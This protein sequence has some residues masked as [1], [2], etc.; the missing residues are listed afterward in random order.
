[1]NIPKCAVTLKS[2]MGYAPSSCVFEGRLKGT[3]QVATFCQRQN[4]SNTL[5][6]PFFSLV[7]KNQLLSEMADQ[8]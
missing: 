1:M 3:D 4:S 5:S 7:R 6:F 2:V 8:K